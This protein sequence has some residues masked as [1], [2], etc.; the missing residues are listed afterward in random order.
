MRNRSSRCGKGAKLSLPPGILLFPVFWAG[1]NGVSGGKGRVCAAAGS[2]SRI[3]V[4]RRWMERIIPTLITNCYTQ[5]SFPVI[6]LSAPFFRMIKSAEEPPPA[7]GTAQVIPSNRSRG[8]NNRVTLLGC[9]HLFV[10]IRRWV[11]YHKHLSSFTA[12]PLSLQHLLLGRMRKR[13]S[14]VSGALC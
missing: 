7:W 14:T 1:S 9:F 10:L 8:N 2:S 3:L 11:Y 12:L 5:Q 6:L 4:Q 13:S